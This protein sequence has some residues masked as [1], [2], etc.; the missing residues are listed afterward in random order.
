VVCVFQKKK[1]TPTLAESSFIAV[2][3]D[4]FNS[5]IRIVVNDTVYSA[6]GHFDLEKNEAIQLGIDDSIFT[7]SNIRVFKGI[8][9]I[10]RIEEISGLKIS[11]ANTYRISQREELDPKYGEE[12]LAISDYFSVGTKL[13]AQKEIIAYDAPE[14]K[15]KLF[16]IKKDDSVELF[17]GFEASIN[18]YNLPIIKKMPYVRVQRSDG[19]IGYVK[20]NHIRYAT[21]AE[22]KN[23]GS[24]IESFWSGE[25]LAVLVYS[26]KLF[27]IIWWLWIIIALSAF[28]IVYLISMK[29]TCSYEGILIFLNLAPGTI[30]GAACMI[31]F[32][33]GTITNQTEWLEYEMT[34]FFMHIRLLP[35][36]F[37]SFT[38]WFLYISTLLALLTAIAAFFVN[39]NISS[40][41]RAIVAVPFLFFL[42]VAI[43][44]TLVYVLTALLF[45]AFFGILIIIGLILGIGFFI[46]LA[47]GDRDVIIINR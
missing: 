12:I 40:G 31:C 25:W 46:A 20:Y 7:V 22:G 37:N 23:L 19:R 47:N 10:D 17:D 16:I 24:S 44:F 3:F 15:N 29:L 8:L 1:A 14:S 27:G 21:R 42:N 13:V 33:L 38:D 4:N 9:P 32:F 5:A 11:N 35:I 18:S 6:K 30:I 43:Y 26:G 34:W 45:I 36:G 41:L 39:C 28:V 2:A